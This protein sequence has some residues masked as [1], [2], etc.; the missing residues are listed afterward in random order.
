MYATAAPITARKATTCRVER[1]HSSATNQG[2]DARCRRPL[3]ISR[4]PQITMPAP[5]DPGNSPGPTCCPGIIGNFWTCTSNTAPSSTK[6]APKTA[7][8]TFIAR[9]L[10]ARA[11]SPA[12]ASLRQAGGLHHDAHVGVAF[13]H[14]RRELGRRRPFHAEAPGGCEVLELLAVPDLLDRVDQT[15]LDVGRHAL[16][17]GDAAPRRHGPAAAHR[18]LHRRHAREQR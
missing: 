7:S 6:I 17:A 18:F 4:S 11:R 16:R 3:T 15:L 12:T 13:R 8:L 9:T 1:I 14:E 2:C 5:I 10:P